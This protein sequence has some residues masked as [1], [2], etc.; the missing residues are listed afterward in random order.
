VALNSQLPIYLTESKFK[1]DAATRI[2]ARLKKKARLGFWSF[3]PNEQ[4]RL[5]GPDAIHNVAESFGVLVHLLP[6]VAA[7]HDVHNLR[8][9]FIARLAANSAPEP[10]LAVH[11]SPSAKT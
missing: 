11:V 3:D 8:A 9:S 10:A 7:D 5:P 1:T 4:P 2:V 6:A